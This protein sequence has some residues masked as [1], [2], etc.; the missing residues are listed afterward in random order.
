MFKITKCDKLKTF[1]IFL[2]FELLKA[3]FKTFIN[4]FETSIYASC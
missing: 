4:T 1:I 3:I 2:K